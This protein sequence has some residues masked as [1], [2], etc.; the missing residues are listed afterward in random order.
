MAAL[1]FP[2]SPTLNQQYA[3]PNGVTYQ[4]DGTAWIVS[5]SAAVQLWTASG[6][7]L[8]PTDPTKTVSAPGDPQG[9]AVLVGATTPKMRLYHSTTIAQSTIAENAGINAS[10]NWVSDDTSKPAWLMQMNAN[11][12]NFYVQ[13]NVASSGN[14][15]WPVM[16][17]LDNTGKLSLPNLAASSS[18]ALVVTA[19]GQAAKPHFGPLGPVGWALRS[20]A[21]VGPG[22]PSLDDTTRPN[23]SIQVDNNDQFAAYR[24]PATA[25]APA[26]TK[27]FYVNGADGKTYCTL[28]NSQ[29]NAPMLIPGAAWRTSAG[30]ASRAAA[31][32]NISS[33]ALTQILASNPITT[34]GGLVII[35]VNLDGRFYP[36]QT[37]VQFLVVE[38]QRSGTNIF[39]WITEYEIPAG[40]FNHAFGVGGLCP[41]LE[42]PAAGTYTYTVLVRMSTTS[43]IY[44]TGSYSSSTIAIYEFA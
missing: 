11:T 14:L 23:W 22:N 13:H 29:I 25:G 20:N 35:C 43:Q 36:V 15:T 9:N 31:A 1:D 34:S 3:A 7:T 32:T 21:P 16:L 2:N 19:V 28:G 18:D 38:I 42:K 10:G 4:W 27:P 12:D 37:G 8:L 39:D 44:R 24:A 5:G 6:T 26:Y 33:T 40:S 41:V 17:G 30:T